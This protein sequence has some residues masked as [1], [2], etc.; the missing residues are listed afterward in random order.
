MEALIRLIDDPD[1]SVYEHVRTEILKGGK[2]IIPYLNDLLDYENFSAEVIIRIESLLDELNFL[3][4][5]DDLSMW[6]ESSEKNL[7][8]GIQIITS[9]QFPELTLEGLKNQILQWQRRIWLE[10]NRR[11]T[12]FEVVERMNAM[13]FENIGLQV[14]NKNFAT[15]YNT[16]INIALED[17]RATPLTTGLIYSIVAQELNIPI[18]GVNFPDRFILAYI[19]EFRIHRFIEPL[20]TGGVLFYLLPFD[21]GKVVIKKQLDA[22]LASKNQQGIREYYEPCSNSSL[23]ILYLD[24]LISSYQKLE[25]VDLVK[26]YGKFKE[27][28]LELA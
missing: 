25:K 9:Y 17:L 15:P 8:Q 22:V 12:A 5:L 2:D 21:R 26:K 13:W 11:M 14:V 24:E 20:G 10:L 1:S 18:Y 7:L 19:D 4:V 23:L 3:R 27:R 6:C 16:F 28:V